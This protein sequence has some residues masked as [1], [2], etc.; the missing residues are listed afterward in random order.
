MIPVSSKEDDLNDVLAK[1]WHLENQFRRLKAEE[2]ALK[3]AIAEHEVR[4]YVRSFRYHLSHAWRAF[5]FT[6]GALLTRIALW[7][8]T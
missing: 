1:L 7:L 5:R 4:E 3:T 8:N 6:W 2:R